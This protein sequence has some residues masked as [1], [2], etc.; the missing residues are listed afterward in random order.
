MRQLINFS[1]I[2]DIAALLK[3]SDFH[4][5]HLKDFLAE[6][7]APTS[8]VHLPS[9][10]TDKPAEKVVSTQ[11]GRQA[12]KLIDLLSVKKSNEH[13]DRQ[14][15]NKERQRRRDKTGNMA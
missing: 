10:E 9:G 4:Q 7:I 1:I 8:S 2:I 15:E 11:P 12:D 13:A 3:S 6:D 14:R 5:G